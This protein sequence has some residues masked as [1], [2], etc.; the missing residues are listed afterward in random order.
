LTATFAANTYTI[1]VAQAGNGTI[2][3]GTSP[4]SYGGS[5][6]FTITPNTGYSIAAV[7][8]DGSS[9]GSVSQYAFTNVQANHLITATYIPNNY[10]LTIRTN[11]QGSV[12]PGN[13]TYLYNTVVTLEESSAAGWSFGGWSTDGTGSNIT[14]TMSSDQTVTAN[15]TENPQVTPT[16][17]PSQTSTNTTIPTAT[18]TTTPNPTFTPTPTTT[19]TAKT[20]PSQS[21]PAL[22][23]AAMGEYI[24]VII[25]AIVLGAVVVGMVIH[26]RKSPNIIVL[27]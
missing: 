1:T 12:T 7:Y 27:N 6:S 26:R 22:T 19:S 11:G 18:P 8:V 3:P 24:P 25:A 20:Q 15:F 21:A 9:V 5:Q 10:T 14:V 16:P 13:G 4:V 23:L 17:T 2:S